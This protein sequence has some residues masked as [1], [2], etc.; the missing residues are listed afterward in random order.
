M[1]AFT[2]RWRQMLRWVKVHVELRELIKAS[3]DQFKSDIPG[4]LS[5]FLLF[6]R[7]ILGYFH[8]FGGKIIFSPCPSPQIHFKRIF[9]D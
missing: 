4:F 8:I 2:A 3:K 9:L 5:I 1:C 7:I 6:F